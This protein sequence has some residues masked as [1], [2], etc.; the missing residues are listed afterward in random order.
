M[1]KENDDFIV[2]VS[3]SNLLI[4]NVLSDRRDRYGMERLSVL[5]EENVQ[6][7]MIRDERITQP[8]GGAKPQEGIVNDPQTD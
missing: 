1:L 4:W 7:E 2:S 6:T 8:E 5:L 3:A